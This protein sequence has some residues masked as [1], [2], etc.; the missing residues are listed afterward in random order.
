MEIP[1]L[2]G[3][4]PPDSVATLVDRDAICRLPKLYALGVD[5]RDD[6]MVRSVFTPDAF[7]RGM[8][9]D[10]PID[11]YV[12]MLIEGV[13]VYEATMHNITNQW[14]T[15]DGDEAS[16]WSAAVALHFEERGNGRVDMAMGVHYRDRLV[17]TDHG[18]LV[19]ARQTEQLWTRGPFP[20]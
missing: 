11:E 5:L 19:S 14:A 8:L 4:L 16:V 13:R 15:V 6:A 12:P 9:G 10:F 20:R 18:W 17:R 3:P 1:D 2:R 7:V